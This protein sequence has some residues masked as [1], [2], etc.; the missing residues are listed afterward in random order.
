M[1]SIRS[2]FAVLLMLI[3]CLTL[4]SAETTAYQESFIYGHSELGRELTCHRIGT[5]DADASILI[6]FG[7]HGFEDAYDHDGKVLQLIAER[8]ISHYASQPE[9]VDGFCLYIVPTA[10]PD[11]M[12]DGK[13]EYGFGRCNAAGLDINREFP[14]KWTP[15]SN[16]R[17]R[18]GTEPFATAEARA[19]RDLV[20]SVNPTY[21][22][23]VHGWIHATY[24]DGKMAEVFA[25]PF[26]FA[27]RKTSSGGMLC[28]WMDE[29]T[30]EGIMIELPASPNT[31]KY[32]T[33]NSEK[34]IQGIDA[35]ISYLK[36]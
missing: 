1:Q 3:V 13:S 5:L 2:I 26:N 22:I 24:G 29:V 36:P 6:I 18:T 20:E 17:N 12:L 35:W 8:I 4:V 14:V 15:S 11:G 34:L 10:N 21:G 31:G 32:I 7:L 30:E 19:I 16:S 9:L 27:V 28:Q 25:T 23:D 33:T